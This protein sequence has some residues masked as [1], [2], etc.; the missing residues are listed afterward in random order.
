MFFF[1]ASKKT[2][3][4]RL[5]LPSFAMLA[6]ADRKTWLKKLDIH[7]VSPGHKQSISHFF[8]ISSCTILLLQ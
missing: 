6:V 8:L 3:K 7:F 2:R 4:L 5:G 1:A